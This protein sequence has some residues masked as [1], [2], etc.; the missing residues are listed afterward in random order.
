MFIWTRNILHYYNYNPT[1][2]PLS[3]LSNH[4]LQLELPLLHIVSSRQ[5]DTYHENVSTSFPNTSELW[6]TNWWASL[7]LDS[8]PHLCLNTTGSCC[9][10]KVFNNYLQLLPINVKQKENINTNGIA[11]SS[12]INKAASSKAKEMDGTLTQRWGLSWTNWTTQRTPWELWSKHA[13]RREP[14]WWRGSSL[15]WETSPPPSSS[16]SSVTV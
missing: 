3:G 16:S 7:L 9:C 5:S 10:L 6:T 4:L 12:A 11:I 8:P 2:N 14:I 15:G 1:Y 13:A